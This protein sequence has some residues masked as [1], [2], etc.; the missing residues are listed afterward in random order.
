[1]YKGISID[2][3]VNATDYFSFQRRRSTHSTVASSLERELCSNVAPRPFAP[4]Q[5]GTVSKSLLSL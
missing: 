4:K 3:F 2:E 5:L 1:M